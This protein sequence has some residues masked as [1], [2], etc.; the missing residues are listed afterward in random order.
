M[1]T[2]ERESAIL[3]YLREEKEADVRTLAHALYVSEP[4]MRRD[5]ALLANE[6]KLIRT[7]GGAVLRYGRGENLPQALR[8]RERSDAKALIAKKCLS[9][10]SDGDT[11][12]VDGSSTA[13][14]LLPLLSERR[15]LVVVTNNANAP[16]L[17]MDAPVRLFVTGGEPARGTCA[18]VGSH[19]EEFLRSFN[20]DISF[21]SVRTLTREGLLTDNALAENDVRRVM[22]EKSKKRVLMLDSE[23]LGEA[24][25]STLTE[26]S[27]IDRVVS[28]RD[29][30]ECFPDFAEKFL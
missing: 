22:L 12:M 6:G 23:K 27:A 10:I 24:C 20:A 13:A 25:L 5:L 2:R 8:E 9:L 4:T 18:L 14:A 3:E 15:S 30:S 17:L 11:V 7:H 16:H 26:L 19:A 21:F 1:G 29:L 28:E